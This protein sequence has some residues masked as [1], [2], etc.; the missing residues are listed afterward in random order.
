MALN[1]KCAMWRST[2]L[3]RRPE[4]RSGK[5]LEHIGDPFP[6]LVAPHHRRLTIQRRQMGV[7]TRNG[8]LL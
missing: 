7:V 4:E 3:H 1:L 6:G 8:D 2:K 5:L